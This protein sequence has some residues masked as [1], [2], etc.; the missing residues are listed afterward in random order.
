[1]AL[2]NIILNSP[3]GRL[4]LAPAD[5]ANDEA[6]A[7]IRCHAVTRQY[8]RLLP[9]HCSTE[10]ARKLREER[11]TDPSKLEF[12]VYTVDKDGNKQFV[13]GTMIFYIDESQKSCE[14]GIILSADV[15][16]GGVATDVFYA[17]LTYIFE[18]RGFHRVTFETSA[19]N[20]AMRGWLEKVADARLESRRVE[21]WKDVGDGGYS[22]VTGYAILDREWKERVKANLARKLG[23]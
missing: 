10:D 16:R 18:E 7:K 6:N 3:T 12:H 11:L 9:E 2:H 21:A 14:V 8:L 5:G 15:H 23:L 4:Q 20:L 1:M 19:E 17:L 13:G 22:D